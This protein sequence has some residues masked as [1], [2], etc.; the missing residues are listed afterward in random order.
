MTEAGEWRLEALGYVDE[1]ALLYGIGEEVCLRLRDRVEQYHSD[2]QGYD[3]PDWS[4]PEGVVDEELWCIAF[5][6]IELGDFERN[7]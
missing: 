3:D 2:E 1:L 5:E 4:D 6:V 7:T